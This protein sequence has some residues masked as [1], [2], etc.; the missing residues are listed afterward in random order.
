MR[1]SA[2]TPGRSACSV[3]ELERLNSIT[4]YLEAVVATPPSRTLSG[5]AIGVTLPKVLVTAL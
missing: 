2:R 1:L 5:R 3:I 4:P